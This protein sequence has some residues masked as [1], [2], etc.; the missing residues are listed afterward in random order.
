VLAAASV[1][2]SLESQAGEAVDQR[3]LGGD[4]LA[5]EDFGESLLTAALGS[6]AA[7]RDCCA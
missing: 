2:K 7:A 4:A 6:F 1:E 3:A 5:D